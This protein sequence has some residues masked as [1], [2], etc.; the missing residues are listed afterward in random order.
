MRLDVVP[1]MWERFAPKAVAPPRGWANASVNWGDVSYAA[2]TRLRGSANERLGDKR[3]WYWGRRGSL[4]VFRDTGYIVDFENEFAGALKDFVARERGVAEPAAIEWLQ[5]E[6]L[7][8]VKRP[9]RPPRAQTGEQGA[10]APDRAESVDLVSLM[11]HRRE[12]FAYW[13]RRKMMMICEPKGWWV[14]LDGRIETEGRV[15]KL[16]LAARAAA[17]SA[18]E[19]YATADTAN[20]WRGLTRRLRGLRAPDVDAF[21]SLHHHESRPLLPSED[22]AW[23]IRAGRLITPSDLR[24]LRMLAPDETMPSPDMTALATDRGVAISRIFIGHY[25]APVAQRLALSLLGPTKRIEQVRAAT[26]DFGKGLLISLMRRAFGEGVVDTLS[27]EDYRRIGKRFSRAEYLLARRLLV[28]LEEVQELGAMQPGPLKSITDDYLSVERKGEDALSLPRIG[29]LWLVGNDWGNISMSNRTMQTRLRWAWDYADA[30]PITDNQGA[31]TLL[32]SH[33]AG[34]VIQ[35]LI[36]QYAAALPDGELW[37]IE[38]E[39]NDARPNS[40]GV[41]RIDRGGGLTAPALRE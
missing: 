10:V 13:E 41:M 23:D 34:R 20:Y 17:R 38:R 9:G 11:R 36:L 12:W 27:L 6:G 5:G 32:R 19:E 18:G 35:A 8:P 37:Q 16:T 7:L 22:G 33:D 29:T 25:G 39:L 31:L 2:V 40:I 14:G 3:A 30:P 15:A 26:S 4:K 28:F 24:P 21:G 1:V